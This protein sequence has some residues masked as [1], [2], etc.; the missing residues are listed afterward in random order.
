MPLFLVPVPR[1]QLALY[2]QVSQKRA[3]V[4]LPV[5]VMVT[6]TEI[7][8]ILYFCNVFLNLLEFKFLVA[9]CDGINCH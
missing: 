6:G 2:P 5:I 7:D 9:G 3:E 1:T 8:T 4:S